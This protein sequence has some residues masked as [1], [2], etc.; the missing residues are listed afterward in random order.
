M[1]FK[2]FQTAIFGEFLNQCVESSKVGAITK[3]LD[4]VMVAHPG[5]DL[6]SHDSY[7][8]EAI[9]QADVDLIKFVLGVPFFPL[10]NSLRSSDRLMAFEEIL[11]SSMDEVKD[12]QCLKTKT[13]KTH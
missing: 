11:M 10:L 6:T 5:L 8:P 9:Q 1:T 7:N 13:Q 4:D 2:L 12:Y 3:A